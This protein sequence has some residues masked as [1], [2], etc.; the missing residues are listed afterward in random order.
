MKKLVGFLLISSAWLFGQAPVLGPWWDS[1]VARDM[2]LSDQQRKQIRETVQ[3]HRDSL[4][5]QRADIQKAEG[6]LQDLMNEEQ[7]S[8]AKVTSAIDRLVA[9]RGAMMKTVS[10]MSL[11]L[12][13]L[14]TPEQWRALQQ[15]RA[16]QR[17]APRRDFPGREG[18]MMRRPGRQVAPN[19]PN[20]PGPPPGGPP[21]LAPEL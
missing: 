2:D 1:P 12:R 5:Q 15:D 10:L 4:I 13:M 11:K 19:A 16:K 3:A 7:V 14:L 6:A 18:R 8:E 17:M 20:P 21:G 9:A